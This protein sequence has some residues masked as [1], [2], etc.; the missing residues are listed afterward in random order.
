[1]FFDRR[2]GQEIEADSLGDE[3]KVHIYLYY[4]FI[5]ILKITFKIHL[6]YLKKYRNYQ[7]IYILL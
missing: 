5:I 7:Y 2:M 1:M 6:K 3:F 4:L